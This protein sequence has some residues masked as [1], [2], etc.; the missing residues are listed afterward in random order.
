MFLFAAGVPRE[1]GDVL[2]P[3]CGLL[4]SSSELCHLE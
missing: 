1:G 2:E 3:D 4:F